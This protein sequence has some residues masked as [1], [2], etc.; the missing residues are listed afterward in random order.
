[1][2]A[3]GEIDEPA[4][5]AAVLK[6]PRP[7]MMEERAPS[8]IRLWVG[9]AVALLLLLVAA[10]VARR[11][12][13][14]P[15]ALPQFRQQR[16]T[17]NP[18]DQPVTSAAISSDGKYLGYSDQQGLHVQV[19]DGGQTQTVPWSSSAGGNRPLGTSNPGIR[20]RRG[21]PHGSRFRA[22]RSASGLSP[23]SRGRRWSSLMTFTGNHGFH[24]TAL[25]L[26]F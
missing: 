11:F 6:T 24:R 14:R 10:S 8:R 26:H 1:M 4:E 16:L 7:L 17:A 13:R 25:W 3:V 22:S 5:K 18:L 19:V 9:L 21:L 20:T 15:E 23:S 2:G 12:A